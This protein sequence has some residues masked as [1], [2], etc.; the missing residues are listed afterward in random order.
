MDEDPATAVDESGPGDVPDDKD[1]PEGIPVVVMA[2]IKDRMHARHLSPPDDPG[3][4]EVS[5]GTADDDVH[6]VDDGLEHCTI[7]RAV[8]YSPDGCVYVLVGRI[9]RYGYEQLRDDDL[10]PAHAFDEARDLTLC[11]VYEVDG[12]VENIALIRRFRHAD[13]VPAD[14]L[15]PGPFLEFS[16]ENAPTDEV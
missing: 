7:G 3:H 5:V 12:S 10:E 8:G 13:D 16:E 4:L 11:G 6:V 15:P 14:Y 2:A 1:S 9:S